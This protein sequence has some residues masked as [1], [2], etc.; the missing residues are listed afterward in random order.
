MG[1]WKAYAWGAVA[2]VMA[3]A[4]FEL[5]VPMVMADMVDYGV[6]NQDMP[7]ILQ[8]GAVMLVCALCALVLGVASSWFS[9]RAGQGLGAQL[10]EEQYRKLQA[11]SLIVETIIA[12]GDNR[13][14]RRRMSE[15]SAAERACP[16]LLRKNVLWGEK[17]R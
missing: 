5:L 4:I 14:Q 9:A 6:A 1:K 2:C 10:R 11:F 13:A 16:F 17:E 8:K 15:K 7:Y 3:E 12:F